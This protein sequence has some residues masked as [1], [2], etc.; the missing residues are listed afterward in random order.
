MHE[1][2]KRTVWVLFGVDF[3]YVQHALPMQP[4]HKTIQPNSTIERNATWPRLLHWNYLLYIYI[5]I[6]SCWGVVD[7]L[8]KNEYH[9]WLAKLVHQHHFQPVSPKLKHEHLSWLWN[10]IS[11][12]INIHML[13]SQQTPEEFIKFGKLH[14]TEFKAMRHFHFPSKVGWN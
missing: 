7:R 8:N 9:F 14:E 11:Q 5:L 10:I 1:T 4:K 3:L 12:C 6:I 13:V 2:K